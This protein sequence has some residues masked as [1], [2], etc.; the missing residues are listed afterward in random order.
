MGLV[1]T[2]SDSDSSESPT[3][4][5]RKLTVWTQRHRRPLTVFIYVSLLLV[6][7]VLAFV[8]S[9]LDAVLA[10]LFG[11]RS[12]VK[13]GGQPVDVVA[14][15]PPPT[16]VVRKV[17]DLPFVPQRDFLCDEMH[18]KVS[19]KT[20]TQSCRMSLYCSIDT[21]FTGDSSSSCVQRSTLCRLHVLN[22]LSSEM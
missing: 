3:T 12:V 18:L 9:Y 13:S 17:F 8:P 20:N 2:D 19:K 4:M 16:A 21:Q 6:L 11:G 14:P 10:P 7:A 1:S 15:R 5:R 22:L